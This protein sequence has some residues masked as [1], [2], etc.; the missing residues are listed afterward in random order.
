M[1]NGKKRPILDRLMD[2]VV[3][4]ESG[5]WLFMGCKLKSGYGKIARTRGK[6]VFA[7]RVAYEEMV[8]PIEAGSYVLHKCDNPSCVNP[9]H[10]FT[11][12]AKDNWLDARSKGRN[13]AAP[14]QTPNYRYVHWIKSKK[15]ANRS[16]EGL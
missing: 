12:S 3:K 15:E 13:F 9:D 10:L 2:K 1:N 5:C 8:G 4:A 6:P 11:G 7:H 14:Q 16:G